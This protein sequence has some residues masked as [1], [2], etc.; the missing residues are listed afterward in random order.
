MA[1]AAVAAAPLVTDVVRY[2]PSAADGSR[3]DAK[4][5]RSTSRVLPAVVDGSVTGPEL[6]GGAAVTPKP[7]ATGPTPV[8]VPTYASGEL[9]T[10]PGGA[11]PSTTRGRLVR[12]RVLVEKG[13]PLDGAEF[14]RTSFRVLNDPRSWAHG[15]EYR[16]EWVTQ[17]PADFQLILASPR[18][19]DLMCRQGYLDTEGLYSCR[20]RDHVVVNAMRWAQGAQAYQ[21]RLA[22]YR[23]YVVNHEVGHRLGH[24]HEGCPG[25][26]RLAPVMMQQTKG[27]GEC[28][29]NPWPYP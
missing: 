6:D 17:G 28:R 24:R 3:E 14:A 10:V 23:I 2:G 4:A 25:P 16:F 18:L 1:G 11:R 9:V 22:A 26:G 21:G 15:G 19:T 13:L 20:V 5:S 29:P 12:Y 7:A 8:E 27:V